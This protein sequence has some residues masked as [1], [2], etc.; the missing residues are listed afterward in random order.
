MAKGAAQSPEEFVN[1][2]QSVTAEDIKKA[3]TKLCAKLA[4]SAYGQINQ[5]PYLDEI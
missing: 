2:V 5:T 4:L 3:A 1:I